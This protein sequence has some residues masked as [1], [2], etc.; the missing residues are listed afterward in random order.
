MITLFAK[1][2][3]KLLL[4]GV[5]LVN[6]ALSA[7]GINK[8]YV[9]GVELTSFDAKAQGV[10]P[11]DTLYVEAGKRRSLKIS[12][13]EGDS[14]NYVIITNIG[15]DAIIENTT[16]HYGFW[17]SGSSYFRL[18][19]SV[20]NR[21]EYGI[22]ILKTG[23]GANGL[24]LDTKCTNYEVDHIEIS[25]TGF[26]GISAFTHPTCDLMS[27]R[28]NFVQR[29]TVIRDNYIHDT[30]GEGM[31]IGH[32]FYNGYTIECNGENKVVYPHEIIGLRV[33]N[34]ILK[35]IGYDA[36]QVCCAIDSCEV[37][38]NQISN[39]GTGNE[40]SQHS[41]IQIGAGTKLRCYN[42]SILS[43]SGTGIMMLGFADSYIYNNVIVNAGKDF[44]ADDAEMRI[45]GI[46]VD[47][48]GTLPNTSHYILNN[49]ILSPK[50]DGIR[51]FS[52]V[53][54]KNIVANN[55][56]V[57]PGSSYVYEPNDYRYIYYKPGVDLQIQNNF[58][59]GYVQSDLCA[60]SIESVYN[61]MKNFPLANKGI[62][63][64][65]YSINVD[66]FNRFRST[67]PSIGAFEYE[68]NSFPYTVKK[69][70]FDFF[71]N[72]ETGVIM[73]ENK[74]SELLRYFMIF[75]S[76][77]GKVFSKKINEPRFFMVNI[78]GL[79]KKGIYIFSIERNTSVFSHKFI[80][81]N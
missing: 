30:F 67:T 11:G 57:N 70:D 34:N 52:T 7:V 32:S 39:Y 77:G 23:K 56:I 78:K 17:I 76:A 43:G 47:D 20:Q 25:N 33:Y 71:Q 44:F 53:S 59:A 14:L 81:T 72:T 61:C 16:F 21:Q 13:V 64:Q 37:Y 75:N 74:S 50:S 49:T 8:N 19:G 62:D 41:G 6:M 35:N 29:N 55:L 48:R 40:P 79:L 80:V 63:V 24:S 69:E 18:T 66:F 36:L 28:G 51:F 38:N 46:F 42:N 1:N 27:N 5:L 15:G 4:I 3:A 58:F 60:D 2:K 22:R 68:L 65:K 73:V 10:L 31:Y 54:S 9:I 26:A 45:H 12:N